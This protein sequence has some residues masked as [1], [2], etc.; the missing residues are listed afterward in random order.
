MGRAFD[1]CFYSYTS[2]IY[3]LSSSDTQN[4]VKE[5]PSPPGLNN[6]AI[7]IRDKFSNALGLSVSPSSVAHLW[8][9]SSTIPK[10]RLVWMRF[11][12]QIELPDDLPEIFLPIIISKHIFLERTFISFSRRTINVILA[13][14][15]LGADLILSALFSPAGIQGV[16]QFKTIPLVIP[17]EACAI[18][19]WFAWATVWLDSGHNDPKEVVLRSEVEYPVIV[20]RITYS[21]EGK[22]VEFN[23]GKRLKPWGTLSVK[24]SVPE[25]TVDWSTLNIG[26]RIERTVPSSFQKLTNL[27]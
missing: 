8:G 22:K 6:T 3:G 19:P 26:K 24:L 1:L 2:K 23:I 4:L 17:L 18:Q 21:S 9:Q 13:A 7:M 27:R 15:D 16:A 11:D 25:S 12:T 20:D 14:D 10:S 5:L